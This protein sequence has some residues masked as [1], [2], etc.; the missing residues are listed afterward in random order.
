M[1][2][3]LEDMIRRFCGYGLK[4]EDSDG[5]TNYWCNTPEILEKG[6][7][8]QLKVDTLKKDLDDINPTESSFKLMLNKVRYN[9]NTSMTDSFEYAK[10]KWYKSHRN[11]KLKVGE[12]ILVSNLNFHNIKCP[13]KLKDSFSGKFIIEA[14]HGSNSVQ[15]ELS[16]E[17]K[18]KHPTFPVSLVKHYT[19]SDKELFPLR[20]ET[21]LEG[22]PLDQSEERKVLKVLEESPLRGNDEIEYLFRYRNPQHED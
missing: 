9:E 13:K 18:N 7:N 3:N 15:V 1:I 10:Q 6:W 11:P 19:P 2:Q 22:P 20:D 21:T 14:L 17:L 12:L 5:F 16:G 4:L 8:P